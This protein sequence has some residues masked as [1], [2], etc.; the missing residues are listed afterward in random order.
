M[1]T[2]DKLLAMKKKLPGFAL[3]E[4]AIALSIMGILVGLSL[5]MLSRLIRYNQI[6]TTKNTQEVVFKAL[7][8]YV[9][10]HKML[11]C[12][13]KDLTGKKQAS[14]E[15]MASAQGILPFAELNIPK[16]YA[17]DGFGRFFTYAIDPSFSKQHYCSVK[18]TPMPLSFNGIDIHPDN[19]IPIILIS[20]GSQGH[21]A[22]NQNFHKILIENA[23]FYEMENSNSDF[24]FQ[25]H[26]PGFDHLV[27][28]TSK[29]LFA[30]EYMGSPCK[31]QSE[32]S[33]SIQYKGEA[34]SVFK[35]KS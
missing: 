32:N 5:P 3:L 28:W 34:Q 22:F 23:S 15:D 1:C 13:A 8:A 26:Q 17:L 9:V 11:P 2:F 14:C 24:I 35:G 27:K 33:I 6:Q 20:H 31:V 12:P 10:L 18:D 21:G 19:P 4:L 7:G 16:N 30:N 25:D 29:E